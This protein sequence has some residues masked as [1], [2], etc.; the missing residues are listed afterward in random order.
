M[1]RRRKVNRKVIDIVKNTKITPPQ[2]NAIQAVEIP[3]K[4]LKTNPFLNF[5][6]L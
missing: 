5:F 1:N 4:M 2:I 3:A 6:A